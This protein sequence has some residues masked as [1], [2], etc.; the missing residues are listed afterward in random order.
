LHD[1]LVIAC[2]F[3][4]ANDETKPFSEM[5][6]EEWVER[7][8]RN[9]ARHLTVP[10]EFICFTEKRREFSEPIEQ[11]PFSVAKPTYEHC[12]E[13][14]KLGRPMILV[15]LDTIVVDNID[16]LARYCLE[17]GKLAMPRDP[18][19]PDLVCNGVGLVP[20]NCHWVYD[21]WLERR[22]EFDGYAKDMNFIRSLAKRGDVAVLDD[23]FPGE[24][25]SYKGHVKHYGL[26]GSRIVYFHGEEKAH[27]LDHEWI[28]RE[29][30]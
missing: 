6:T 30:R 19:F 25:V 12:L 3:W 7:L 11:H 18:F 14:Y 24:I 27:Q 10:F 8:Y 5:Y 13:P 17:G 1:E 28:E 29:W 16:H 22:D 20:R 26:D 9:F 2:P 4:D 15:G 21:E 23:L